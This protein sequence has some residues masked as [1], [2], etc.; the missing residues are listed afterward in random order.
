MIQVISGNLLR[1][2]SVFHILCDNAHS[3]GL[4]ISAEILTICITYLQKAWWARFTHAFRCEL[5]Y[6]KRDREYFVSEDVQREIY[7]TIIVFMF[8]VTEKSIDTLLHMCAYRDKTWRERIGGLFPVV[9]LIW[10]LGPWTWIIY[11]YTL[12]RYW[13][14]NQNERWLMTLQVWFMFCMLSYNS[15]MPLIIIYT[16]SVIIIMILM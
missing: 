15:I 14:F 12:A 5:N 16:V 2:Q 11:C 1:V 8:F 3:K 4:F 6:A 10:Q 9:P 13:T 7:H